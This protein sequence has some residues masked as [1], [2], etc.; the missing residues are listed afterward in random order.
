MIK[1]IQRENVVFQENILE[2]IHDIKQ[3]FEGMNI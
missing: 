1:F 2:S 3:K